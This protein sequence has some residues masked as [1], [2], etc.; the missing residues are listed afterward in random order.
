MKDLKV[1][2]LLGLGSAGS[3]LLTII[4]L[5]GYSRTLGVDLFHYF[6]LNDYFRLAI[7]WLPPT[8]VIGIIGTLMNAFFT[9]VERGATEKEIVE[10]S[11]TPRFTKYFRRIGNMAPSVVLVFAALLNTIWPAVPPMPPERLYELWGVAGAVLWISLLAWYTKVPKL[12]QNWTRSWYFFVKYFPALAI[13][14]FCFGLSAGKTGMHPFTRPTSDV[15]IST[16]G[17]ITPV[18]GRILFLL[19][20]YIVLRGQN[21]GGVVIVPRAEVTEI[22]PSKG[23]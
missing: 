14:I 7:E 8:I 16:K 21:S 17:E 22:L 13:F 19:D 2:D 4:Y 20:E 3:F 6:S 5:H 11:P 10:R 12:I 18:K 15:Q 23:S 1:A 9:R